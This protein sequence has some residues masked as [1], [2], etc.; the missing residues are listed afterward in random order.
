MMEIELPKIHPSQQDM[1]LIDIL[2]RQD[3]DL[4]AGRE[5]F[6]FSY[7]Q[8]EVE[9]RRQREQEEEKRQQH[10]R[11]QEKALLA[12]LQLDEETGEFVPRS[13]PASGALTQTNTTNGEIAQNG[14][15]AAQEGD[16]LS[17]DECMQ[18]LAETFPLDEPAESAPPCLD[19]SVPPTTDL[20]MPADIP[21][22]AQNP[23]QPG[24]L[25]QAWMELLS[26]PELQCLN[27][28]MQETLNMDGFMKP[29]GEA[30][31]PSYSQYLPGMDHLS[32]VQTEVCPPEYI[33]TYDGSFNNMVSP[34]LS[35]MSLNVPDVGAEF[36]PEEFNELFY[37]EMEAKVNS[38]PLTSD[39]GNMVS[40]LAETASDSPVNPMDLQ[41]F[42]PGNFSSGK[43]EPIVEF[44]DSDSGLSLDSS[45][46]MS[47]PG[48]SLNGDGS[49]GFSDS[50]SEE[51]DGSPGGT[52][53]DYTEIFPLVYLNDGAQTSLS[54]KSSAEQQ[55]MK[56]KN[57][58]TEPV[59]ASG[60]SKPPFTKDKQKKRS[61]A[62]LSRDEQRAKALQIPFT[63]DMIINL[64]VDDFNEMMSKHQLNEAQLALV[65]DIRRRGKN[66]V[67]AQNCRKRKL[68]NIVGLE[69]EL[70]SLKEEKERLKKEKSE[71]STSLREMKQQLSTL[72]QEV[73]GM[74]RDEQGKPF[75]PNEYSLQHT[76][77]GTVFLVPRLKKTLVKNN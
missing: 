28:Q 23:L 72:Y 59:E 64:P 20:M 2:W 74:L 77:D 73:F 29:S 6:D 65:R 26:L 10:L 52:E 9:L 25:D 76:A 54:D 44:P 71:R 63:V 17:F 53:S 68:E 43:P 49:F 60:Y 42:S 7:R 15:F 36:R 24:S 51:M 14:A 41:S 58:K 33:N 75:S 66:K 62:R 19:V 1:E 16:A 37:P 12:Q 18:L 48:K 70:D 22:F 35:Q 5:V 13:L 38:G 27:M 21:A 40:Q 45:P 67:A 11:E 55:E 8:K 34:N 32:S 57:P 46:H 4:G 69:Y 61:E 3:V 39:G 50:D 56:G 31:N 30:Q 47:S